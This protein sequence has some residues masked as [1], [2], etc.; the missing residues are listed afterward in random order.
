MHLCI[1]GHI[2]YKCSCPSGHEAIKQDSAFLYKAKMRGKVC[3]KK[4]AKKL[5]VKKSYKGTLKGGLKLTKD[6]DEM[7]HEPLIGVVDDL[8]ENEEMDIDA[9]IKE[10]VHEPTHFGIHVSQL[11]TL[12]PDSVKDD[13]RDMSI[14]ANMFS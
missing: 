4:T 10:H 11:E 1:A 3:R 2:D 14:I 7:K 5:P 9:M 13:N 6:S 12:V 8:I